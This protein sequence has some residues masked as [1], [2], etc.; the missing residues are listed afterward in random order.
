MKTAEELGIGVMVRFE[1]TPETSFKRLRAMGLSHCQFATLPDEYLYGATGR[2]N[3][4][5]L[6]NAIEEYDICVTSL[7]ISFPNQDWSNWKNS[8]GLVPLATRAQRMARACRSAYWANELGIVQIASHVGAIPED[9]T[10]PI[11]PDFVEAMRGFCQLLEANGQIMAYET[12]Q[13]SVKTLART[14]NDINVGNQRINFDPANLLMYNQE[15][16]MELVTAMGQMI[17]HIHCKD[18]CRPQKPDTLGNETRL[19]DGD[20]NFAKLFKALYRQGYRGPLTIE[21]EISPGTEQ[22]VDILHAVKLLESLKME[23]GKK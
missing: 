6:L 9:P 23:M 21:R 1:E 13:E 2:R 20:T 5:N 15:D 3:T 4:R 17:V 10:D 12:G 7:F 8:I 16:P 11:Y 14:M 18:G 22:Q 19:G